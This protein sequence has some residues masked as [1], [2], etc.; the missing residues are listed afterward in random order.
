[1]ESGR[2]S[3]S[4]NPTAFFHHVK[5]SQIRMLSNLFQTPSSYRVSPKIPIPLQWLVYSRQKSLWHLKQ[6][7]MQTDMRREGG[8]TL[9]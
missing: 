8:L 5:M 7:N 2:D 6:K 9:T 4:L 3:R 1:M